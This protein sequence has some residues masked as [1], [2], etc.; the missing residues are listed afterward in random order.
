MKAFRQLKNSSTTH[1]HDHAHD[2]SSCV[3]GCT[4]YLQLYYLRLS[5][6]KVKRWKD[7]Q[8]L[9][10][11]PCHGMGNARPL[12][13]VIMTTPSGSCCPRVWS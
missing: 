9:G 13:P 10:G 7:F 8:N 3:H 2:Y 1:A 12:W 5:F 6:V 11:V 4:W